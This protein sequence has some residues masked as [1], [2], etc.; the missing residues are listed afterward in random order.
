MR[1]KHA[2]INDDIWFIVLLLAVSCAEDH[3]GK[4]WLP[5]PRAPVPVIHAAAAHRVLRH[6]F[7]AASLHVLPVWSL[8]GDELHA[9]TALGEQTTGRRDGAFEAYLRPVLGHFH[10][11]LLNSSRNLG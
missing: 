8:L 10:D 3:R 7:Y 11:H 1:H 6:R 5:Q 4:L 9:Q 2:K